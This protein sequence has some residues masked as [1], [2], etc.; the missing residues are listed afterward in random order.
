MI[1]HVVTAAT[2][3]VDDALVAPFDD[4]DGWR[5]DDTAAV[6]E[7]VRAELVRPWIAERSAVEFAT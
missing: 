1:T 4:V 5:E 6:H 7:A 2:G 3:N